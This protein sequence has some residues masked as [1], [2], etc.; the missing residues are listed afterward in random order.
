M[1]RALDDDP[2]KIFRVFIHGDV[3]NVV[4]VRVS[5]HTKNLDQCAAFAQTVLHVAKCS[6]LGQAWPFESLVPLE[7]LLK[8]CEASLAGWSSCAIY[9]SHRPRRDGHV[10]HSLGVGPRK[11]FQERAALLGLTLGAL[12]SCEKA[13]QKWQDYIGPGAPF[14]EAAKVARLLPRT[15][16]RPE[17]GPGPQHAF[18]AEATDPVPA[19]STCRAVPGRHGS[20]PP[21]ASEAQVT[22][23]EALQCWAQGP[24][25]WSNDQLI[26]TPLERKDLREIEPMKEDCLQQIL[27][28]VRPTFRD[29]LRSPASP[30]RVSLDLVGSYLPWPRILAAHEKMPQIIGSGLVSFRLMMDWNILDQQEPLLYFEAAEKN[31]QVH[32]FHSLKRTHQSEQMRRTPTASADRHSAKSRLPRPRGAR[33]GRRARLARGARAPRALHSAREPGSS[34]A[35]GITLQGQLCREQELRHSRIIKKLDPS[36]CP[37]AEKR[38]R[39][40]I[41]RASQDI[42][43]SHAAISQRFAQGE[44]QGELVSRLVDDLVAG[45]VDAVNLP[46]I[47]VIRWHGTHY[48]IMGNR[49]LRAYKEAYERGHDVEFRVIVHPFPQLDTL[50]DPEEQRAFNAK[51]VSAMSTKSDGKDVRL[52]S[53]SPLRRPG[54]R[55]RSPE[56]RRVRLRPRPASE[57]EQSRVSSSVQW[58]KDLLK[59]V[60]SLLK[61]RPQGSNG[62]DETVDVDVIEVR[63]VRPQKKAMPRPAKKAMPRPAK[64]AMPAP[65][66][67]R[68]SATSVPSY[69]ETAEIRLL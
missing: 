1:A 62:K 54:R 56:P 6:E 9:M 68:T 27:D 41:F 11:I 26:A 64:K 23:D 5:N 50:Q 31:G 24:A 47:V 65:A 7:E 46:P 19:S 60:Q 43:Y 22:L 42:R 53:R 36:V 13:E 69:V 14:E 48:V 37:E 3:R 35:P 12:L 10:L 29:K 8:H 4:V 39:A 67:A 18:P 51:V 63:E 25:T 32:T 55:P 59:R 38:F 20:A 52:R 44:H 30:Q 45:H 2:P 21:S 28:L 66:P 33:G 61:E 40:S 17:K 57:A 49:R 15:T 34:R 16:I 58:R